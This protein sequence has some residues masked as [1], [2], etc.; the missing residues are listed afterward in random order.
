[1][2]CRN[3]VKKTFT[4]RIRGRQKGGKCGGAK[5]EDGSEKRTQRIFLPVAVC[6]KREDPERKGAA[7]NGRMFRK[8][9]GR[10]AVCLLQLNR[11]QSFAGY[12]AE[13]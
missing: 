3:Y 11:S 13:R 6:R 2:K 5:E 4:F 8:L 9:R 10:G 1:M 12:P 7:S